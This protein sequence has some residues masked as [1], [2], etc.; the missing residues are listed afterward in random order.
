MAA[1]SAEIPLGP[2]TDRRSLIF[3][4]LPRIHQPWPVYPELCSRCRQRWAVSPTFGS[5][6]ISVEQFHPLLIADWTWSESRADGSRL[7]AP[8]TQPRS[9]TFDASTTT[10]APRS[11]CMYAICMHVCMYVCMYHLCYVFMYYNHGWSTTSME[12]C[13]WLNWL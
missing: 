5:Y 9:P 10:R 3:L 7:T 13:I 2:C 6:P 4:P 12:I 11:V 8:W 1:E